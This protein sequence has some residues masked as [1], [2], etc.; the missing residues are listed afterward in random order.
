M[1]YLPP[2]LISIVEV[3]L[4]IVPALLS[5]AYVT[6]AE[7]KTMA[8]MQRR[9]GPNQVGLTTRNS[10]L[11]LQ[12]RHVAVYLRNKYSVHCFHSSSKSLSDANYLPNESNL[13]S[14]ANTPVD[15][16]NTLYKDR[17]APVIPFS[18]PT[19]ISCNNFINKGKL[20]SASIIEIF[21]GCIYRELPKKSL[22]KPINKSENTNPKN[23]LNRA[24]IN[25]GIITAKLAS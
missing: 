20:N 15:I 9:I 23:I 5:V 18:H 13:S 1:L 7:R 19:L 21:E 17:I 16:I 2:T 14:K 24:K 25:K 11:D 3:L 4:V 22:P 6:V 12:I 10:F 8:S